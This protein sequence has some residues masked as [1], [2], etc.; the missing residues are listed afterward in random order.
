VSS[1]RLR[2]TVAVGN[3]GASFTSLTAMVTVIRSV[4]LA[5]S[6]TVTVTV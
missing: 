5:G 3:T 6:V 1:E 2:V 4:A